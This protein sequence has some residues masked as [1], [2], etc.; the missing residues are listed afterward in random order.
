MTGPSLAGS[1][2]FAIVRANSLLDGM[3]APVDSGFSNHDRKNRTSSSMRW[4]RGR[5]ILR[6]DWDDISGLVVTNATKIRHVNVTGIWPS[7]PGQ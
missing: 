5:A 6:G 4:F 1:T 2:K 7:R 3:T